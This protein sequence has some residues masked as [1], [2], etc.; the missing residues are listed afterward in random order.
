MNREAEFTKAAASGPATAYSSFAAT[1]VRL[2]R[3][4]NFPFLGKNAI[5]RAVASAKGM[6]WQPS[7]DGIS[8]SGDLVYLY[9]T[10]QITGSDS[11][12]TEA[13]FLRIW[14]RRGNTWQIVLDVVSPLQ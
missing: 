4:G 6:T 9:G 13:N 14:Q 3:E 12:T 8:T 10:T 11:K 2:F 1:E 7:G 5:T